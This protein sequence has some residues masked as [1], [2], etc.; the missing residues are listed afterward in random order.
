MIDE[1]N[2]SPNWASIGAIVLWRDSKRVSH[3]FAGDSWYRFE[4]HIVEWIKNGLNPKNS[5]T[6]VASVKLR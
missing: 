5:E 1:K 3:Y 4:D 2:S 6:L